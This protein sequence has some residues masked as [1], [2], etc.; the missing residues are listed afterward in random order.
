M[1]NKGLIDL[2]ETTIIIRLVLET[3][4]FLGALVHQVE[5]ARAK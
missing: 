5:G 3:L 4:L 1:G 2:T